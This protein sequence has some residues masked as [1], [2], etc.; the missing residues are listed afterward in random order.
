MTSK[1]SVAYG[2]I[3]SHCAGGGA[4]VGDSVIVDPFECAIGDATDIGAV[5]GVAGDIDDV[6]G[7]QYVVGVSVQSAIRLMSPVLQSAR[8]IPS[9]KPS[10][11]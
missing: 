2:G 3:V 10:M 7:G 1:I 8:N 5:V 6:V 9:N 4:G 11:E